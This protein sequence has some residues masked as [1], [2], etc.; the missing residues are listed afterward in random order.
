[1]ADTKH[2]QHRRWRRHRHIRHALHGTAARP[3][4]AV[5]R[6]LK[7]IYAQIIDDDAGH[8]LV[9]SSSRVID[10]EGA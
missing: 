1:M 3:R 9:A 10:I 5:F 4:L 8:T 7:H 6:S 2:K